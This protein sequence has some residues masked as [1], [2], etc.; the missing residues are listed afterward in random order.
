[1][2]ENEEHPKKVAYIDSE[3]T[4]DVV[5]AAKLG[6]DVDDLILI[7][8]EEQNAEVKSEEVK[9]DKLILPPYAFKVIAL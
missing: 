3:I 8:P 2:Q 9:G 4:L 1:M 7:Q 6:V 5:W